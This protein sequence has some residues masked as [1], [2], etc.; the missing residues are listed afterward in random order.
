[1]ATQVEN[2]EAR[3]RLRFAEVAVEN[4]TPILI[5]HGFVCTEITPYLVRF[6]STDVQLT[7]I[8]DPIS[9]EIGLF[10]ARRNDPSRRFG[11]RDILEIA[12]GTAQNIGCVFQASD[13]D[14]VAAAVKAIAESLGK[15]GTGVLTGAPVVYQRMADISRARADAYTKEVVQSPLREAAKEAWLRH[16]YARI[17]EL[18][19]SIEADLTPSERRRLKYAKDRQ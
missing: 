14:R 19:E 17:R 8:H 11:L 12:L 9:Y 7:I 4:F 5:V 13:P 2:H 16:D 18:Y 6:E 3:K 15:C 1:M 10:V